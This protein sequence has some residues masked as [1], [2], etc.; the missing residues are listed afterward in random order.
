MKKIILLFTLFFVATMS[1]FAQCPPENSTF[2]FDED[3]FDPGTV[4]ATE[5]A[6]NSGDVMS[7]N[8]DVWNASSNSSG[9]DG[10]GDIQ[11]TYKAVVSY[12]NACANQ[13]GDFL[14]EASWGGAS[15]PLPGPSSGSDFGGATDDDCLCAHGYVVM[16]VDFTDAGTPGGLKSTAA[17]FNFDWSS[18]NGSS[19]GY[20]YGFGFVSAG[21]D[22]NGA[23][24]SG[25]N[26]LAAVETQLPT[27]C[28]AQYV[29]GTTVSQHALASSTGVFTNQGDALNATINDCNT[30]GERGEDTGSGSGPNSGGDAGGVS[31]LN[32]DDMITQV[33]FIYGLS[34]APGSDCTFDGDTDDTAVNTNPSGSFSGITLCVPP[35]PCGIS[36]DIVITEDCGVYDV[37]ISNVAFEGAADGYTVGVS[38]SE[39]GPFT[40]IGSTYTGTAN[41]EIMNVTLPGTPGVDSYYFEL[42]EDTE[43]NC[44]NVF[45]P[46]AAPKENIP[47]CTPLITG[48][49]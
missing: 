26:T 13:D 10:T 33:T 14:I 48:G 20:E 19:E 4:S 7:N 40:T 43:A 15:L 2:S 31:G 36:A 25:L 47:S 11:L 9:T 5:A 42:I 46:I 21:T 1:V 38:T 17:G 16:V 37:E 12:P 45:G 30:S 34:N 18:I 35:P 49:E 27:Y 22:V 6:P 23:P 39:T 3:D 28:N 24:L 41:Q 8:L 44:S 29:A 32:P